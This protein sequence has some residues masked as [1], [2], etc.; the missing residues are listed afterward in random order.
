MSYLRNKKYYENLDVLRA[1]AV[2][3]TIWAHYSPFE[4]PYLWYGVSIFFSISGFL[5]TEILLEKKETKIKVSEI[6]KTFYIRRSLRLFP[7][8]Y[9]FILF[10]WFLLHFANLHIWQDRFNY[11][12]IFYAP[13]FLISQIS[14]GGAMG[15]A[16]LWSLGV[17]E[18]FYLFWPVILLLTPRRWMVVT[19]TF[20]ICV[21]LFF[22]TVQFNVDFDT[23]LLP[24]SHF[25]TLC[26]GALIAVF[27]MYYPKIFSV[28]ASWRFRLLGIAS[29]LLLLALI[30][31][32][33]GLRTSAFFQS[34]SLALFTSLLVLYHLFSFPRSMTQNSFYRA[35]LYIGKISYGLYIIHMPIPYVVR[36]VFL[37]IQ[38][39]YQVNEYLVVL[40]SLIITFVFAALSFK[41]FESYFIRLKEKF[42]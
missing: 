4:I 39:A 42:E 2:L 17:E 19:I 15:F 16:H 11:Y 41:Y 40:L 8:Y 31:K 25:H 3:M 9:S 22:R 7:L 32:D 37:K 30:F 26:G 13:N 23:Y 10:F 34:T 20:F 18:Q 38:P 5:I 35:L 33:F 12:F 1:I 24:F 36:A 14:L 29:I 6:L 27:K 28:L 21:G